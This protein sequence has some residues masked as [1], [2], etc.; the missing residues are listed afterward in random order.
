MTGPQ[1]LTREEMVAIV[2]NVI[3][4]P[5]RY[6]EIPPAAARMDMIVRG[7][8]ESIVDT[9]LSMWAR[10]QG[11]PAIVVADETAEALRR[12]PHT[13]A[14]WVTEHAGAFAV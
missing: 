6:Q 2:G 7:M 8:P 13:F 14:E 9:M 3:G 5:L 12:P 10:S 1:S 11:Q 4:R